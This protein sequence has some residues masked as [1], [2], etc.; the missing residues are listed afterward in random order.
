MGIKLGTKQEQ[1]QQ[2]QWQ[3]NKRPNLSI[4]IHVRRKTVNLSSYCSLFAFVCVFGWR[5]RDASYRWNAWISFIRSLS[6]FIPSVFRPIYVHLHSFHLCTVFIFVSPSFSFVLCVF[7]LLI[8]FHFQMVIVFYRRPEK[9]FPCIRW[10]SFDLSFV[11]PIRIFECC[12]YLWWDLQL[13]M[14]AC[15]C[16]CTL[17]KTYFILQLSHP[18]SVCVF[19]THFVHISSW[20]HF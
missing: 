13:C 15:V 18:C 4:S 10:Q 8:S 5:W 14:C 1:Q 11:F 17:W 9:L 16:V 7:F 6:L 3:F 20:V 12:C 2:Q 19:F